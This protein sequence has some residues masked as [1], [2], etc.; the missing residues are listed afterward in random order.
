MKEDTGLIK[1]TLI[2]GLIVLL[3]VS[4]LLSACGTLNGAGADVENVGRFVREGTQKGVDNMEY[5]RLRAAEETR[6][7]LMMRGQQIA[8][9]DNVR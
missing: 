1:G 7:R 6:S 8:G 5:R 2:V 9:Y 3:A 4:T